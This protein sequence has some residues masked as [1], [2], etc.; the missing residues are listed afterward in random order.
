V[1]NEQLFLVFGIPVLYNWL[2]F[3]ILYSRLGS[4]GS[5]F[6]GIGGRFSGL[7]AR[8]ANL[9]QTMATRSDLLLTKLE[10]V[11]ARLARLLERGTR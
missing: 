2:M 8:L 1:T 11:D 7:D 6:A 5:R 4:S 10:C 9:E 3:V